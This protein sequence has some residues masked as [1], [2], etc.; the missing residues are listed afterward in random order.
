MVGYC[1]GMCSL[2]WLGEVIVALATTGLR[3]SELA[4]L[5]WTDL[6]FDSNMIH[7]TDTRFHGSKLERTAG[8]SLKSHRNRSL[9]I[10]PK[11][12]E[13]LLAMK[14]HADGRVFHG[15]LGG[16]LKPDTVRNVLIREVLTPLEKKFPSVPAV[17]GFESGRLHSLRHYFCAM[18]ANNGVPE[19]ALVSW[20]GHRDSKMVR[21]Y[22]HL[23]QDEAQ[24]QIAKVNF[25][26]QLPRLETAG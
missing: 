11:L 24:R 20:L 18:S 6:H 17:N 12:R 3:I 1:R 14:H 19:Q 13:Q 16:L 26:G 22:Y 23:H 15:P 9:P 2:F 4:E 5:R 10:Y 8:R 21:H 25:V 7:L